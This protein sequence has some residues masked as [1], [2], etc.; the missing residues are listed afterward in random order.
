MYDQP[1]S[2]VRQSLSNTDDCFTKRGIMKMPQPSKSQP[3]R[4]HHFLWRLCVMLFV[5]VLCSAPSSAQPIPE[6][7]KRV[8]VPIDQFQSILHRDK[9]GVLL[10]TEE[11]EN[12]WTLAK[13]NQTAGPKQSASLVITGIEYDAE[14]KDHSLLVTA[15]INLRQFT[16]GWQSIPLFLKNIVIEEAKLGEEPAYIGRDSKGQLRFFHN[17]AGNIQL[18]L[19]LVTRLAAMGSDQLASFNLIPGPAASMSINI[20][21]GKH[22]IFKGRSLDRPAAIEEEATYSFPVGNA[23]TLM[24]QVTDRK[25]EATTDSLVFANSLIGVDAVPGE[26]RWRSLTR[27]QLYGQSLNQIFLSVSAEL[28][29]ADVIS[30]GLDSWEMNEDPDDEDLILLTLN[31][32]QPM[33]GEQTIELRGVLSMPPDEEWP[34]PQLNVK[35]VDSHVGHVIITHPAAVRLQFVTQDGLRRAKLFAQK[36]MPKF[37][38]EISDR[39]SP[40]VFEFYRQDFTL[41]L[42]MRTRDRELI[43]NIQNLLE[44]QYESIQ[45]EAE[46]T[47][48]CRYAPLFELQIELPAE[49]LPTGLT[50]NGQPQEWEDQSEAAGTRQLRVKLSPPLMPG[51][52]LKVGLIAVQDLDDWPPTIDPEEDATE[53]ELPQL[54]LPQVN[55]YDGRYFLSSHADFEVRPVELFSL[56]RV[57]LDNNEKRLTYEYQD[58]EFTG[59]FTVRR[60]PTHLSASM[61]SM[62]RK[63]PRALRSYLQADVTV[64]GSGVREL[65]FQLPESTGKNVRFI[66]FGGPQRIVEQV[67]SEAEAGEISWKLTFDRRLYGTISVAVQTTELLEAD[68]KSVFA[69]RLLLKNAERQFG[70]IAIEA[71]PEQNLTVN[72]S[73]LTATPLREVDPGEIPV[74]NIAY[75]PQER[76]VAAYQFVTPE[77]S[78]ELSSERFDRTVV[79]LAIAEEMTLTSVLSE[80]GVWQHEALINFS[81]AGVQNLLVKL[82]ENSTLWSATLDDEPIEVRGMQDQHL[83]PLIHSA[84]TGSSRQLKMVYL[85]ESEALKRSGELT[86]SPPILSVEVDGQPQAVEVLVTNWSVYSPDSL[87]FVES[88]GLFQSEHRFE[89]DSLLTRTMAAFERVSL[90]RVLGVLVTAVGMFGIV[91]LVLRNNSQG[92]GSTLLVLGVLLVIGVGL[93]ALMLP[94]VQQ[95]REYARS[96]DSSFEEPASGEYG[97]EGYGY[98]GNAGGLSHFESNESDFDYNVQDSPEGEMETEE[99]VPEESDIKSRIKLADEIQRRRPAPPH[100]TRQ[101]TPQPAAPQEQKAET[102][103]IQIPPTEGEITSLGIQ[104]SQTVEEDKGARLSVDVA[105]QIPDDHRVSDFSYHGTQTD[106]AE[107]PLSIRYL[108]RQSVGGLTALLVSL[109]LIVFYVLRKRP[110]GRRLMLHAL[111]LTIPMALMPIWPAYGL[112]LLDGIVIGSL[113]ASVIWAACCCWKCCCLPICCR[114]MRCCQPKTVATMLLLTLSFASGVSA[115]PPIQAP[116]NQAAQ[117]PIPTQQANMVPAP[118]PMAPVDWTVIAPYK[119][120][121]GPFS[122]EKIFL[123]R[124]QYLE[125]WNRAHPEDPIG[126]ESPGEATV[127]SVAFLAEVE[128][129]GD[130]A[131]VKVSARFVLQSFSTRPETANIPLDRVALESATLDSESVALLPFQTKKSSGYRVEL[132]TKGQY[133]LDLV[134]RLPYQQIGAGGRFSLPLTEKTIGRLTVKL[135]SDNL[136]V[137][138]NGT[139]TTYRRFREDDQDSILLPL[140]SSET[141]TIS[142]SPSQEEAGFDRIIHVDTTSALSATDAGLSLIQSAAYSIPQGSIEETLFQLPEGWELQSITGLD[143]GGWE[144][145]EEDGKRLLRIFLRRKVETE[146]KIHFTMFQAVEFDDDPLELNYPHLVPLQVTGEKGLIGLLAEEQLR[147]RPGTFNFLS[148]LEASQFPATNREPILKEN[149]QYAYRYARSDYQLPLTIIRKDP[150]ATA[151]TRHGLVVQSARVQVASKFHVDLAS[152]PRSRISIL[153]PENYVVLDVQATELQDW[154]QT[155]SADDDRLLIVEFPRILSGKLEIAL[156][157]YLRKEPMDELAEVILPT[158]LEMSEDRTHLAIWETGSDQLSIDDIDGW[159]SLNPRELPAELLKLQN[160]LPEFAFEATQIL[161]RYLALLI[162]KTKPQLK[163]DTVTI[164]NVTDSALIYQLAIKW[165]ISQAT[166]DRFVFT[167]SESLAGKLDFTDAPFLQSY[168]SEV[169]DDGR[170]RWKLFLTQPQSK[171]YFVSPIATLPLPADGVLTVPQLTVEQFPHGEEEEEFSLL[172]RQRHFVAL[173]NQ[174]Q[175]QLTSQDESVIERIQTSELPINP[176]NT[177]VE[178]ATEL[179][180]VRAENTPPSWKIRSFE[181]KRGAA[182]IINFAELTTVL[183]QDGSWRTKASYLVRNSNRQFLALKIPTDAKLLA[184]L[185]QTQPVRP[186]VTELAGTSIT[187]LPLPKTSE[188]DLS[189]FVEVILAGRLSEGSLVRGLKSWGDKIDLPAPSIVTTRESAQFGIPVTRTAWTVWLPES[190]DAK[191]VDDLKRTN[192]SPQDS[193]AALIDLQVTQLKEINLMLSTASGEE[194]AAL[195]QKL[196]SNVEQL[197]TRIAAQKRG[198]E[199]YLSFSKGKSADGYERFEEEQRILNDNRKRLENNLQQQQ[200][201]LQEDRYDYLLNNFDTL[202]AGSQ[203]GVLRFSNGAL[204]GNNTFIDQNG[205]GQPNEPVQLFFGVEKSIQKPAAKTDAKVKQ[206]AEPQQQLK[207]RLSN[208]DQSGSF[209]IKLGNGPVESR[210]RQNMI[211]SIDDPFGEAP[212]PS[213]HKPSRV[214]NSLYGVDGLSTQTSPG[215]G[216]GGFGGGRMSL[217]EN[218][219]G[220]SNQRLNVAGDDLDIGFRQGS[221]DLGETGQQSELPGTSQSTGMSL[222]FDVPTFGKPITFS[223]VG[224]EPRLALEIK[225]QDSLAGGRR[226]MWIVLWV[227]ISIGVVRGVLSGRWTTCSHREIGYGIAAFG[228]LLCIVLPLELIFFGLL[229]LLSGL[230]IFLTNL[231]NNQTCQT[232]QQQ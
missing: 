75:Q 14:I 5:T 136:L 231:K 211:E 101:A 187:L 53:I 186:V 79:P 65:S 66:T 173:V 28:E 208:N 130:A 216:G 156:K 109:T 128:G 198:E 41:E 112:F 170:I 23:D 64:E 159:K 195:Q 111:T 175:Y 132:P 84:N 167:T 13:N 122:A 74:S 140:A 154:Y 199:K 161:D 9:E 119:P 73:S 19:Q 4:H 102:A 160:K 126:V 184:A 43:A 143:V 45:Y 113:I 27:L 36:E 90:F 196:L 82:P 169:T 37:V 20:P 56:N 188:S 32:R 148:Q 152:T 59:I 204:I 99:A 149:V 171:G 42:L 38:T 40:Q 62:V 58:T 137:Q 47:L 16:N 103:A 77:Y 185:V 106:F 35:N 138:V 22:L 191:R 139:T 95:S 68:Q 144:L 174:S 69:P 176:E 194:Q 183:E 131:S 227:V 104:E 34:V 51:H 105:L 193:T 226:I 125:L 7:P 97:G 164:V 181:Q 67:P 24:L 54:T 52:E 3:R 215:G 192:L 17:Q 116:A 180:R 110:L 155:F 10:E 189:F 21:A 222:K 83:I 11:F 124:R 141:I 78:V 145:A 146:T 163:A 123:N 92:L 228:L 232:D 157:G 29:I 209:G 15:Q 172:D 182:A 8:Y 94:S 49:W 89:A 98:G 133:L 30:G 46:I 18:T 72:P 165:D 80:S 91:C 33:T 61:L 71:G 117:P 120:S 205:D 44:L 201:A 70:N 190:L 93:F 168:T 50:I 178:K 150:A 210:S 39:V 1:A 153:L 55:L 221:F 2:V 220:I 218:Q 224:G 229:M 118:P 230:V 147:I 63:D 25:K 129:E 219:N 203:G 87:E 81:A 85:T 48:A 88:T 12:L 200:Q 202:D 166:S 212:V 31:Y 96:L 223:K 107:S 214:L 6:N 108:R 127:S 217:L 177:L 26:I 86:Q 225:P 100:M 158:L 134:F 179:F 151:E 197:N 207:K 76:I 162:E 60:R 213:F 121:E 206:Q 57:L 114:L 135:P 142:W 115:A